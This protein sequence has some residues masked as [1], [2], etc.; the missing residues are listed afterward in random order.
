M[1]GTG[2]TQ[3]DF[4]GPFELSPVWRR[5]QQPNASTP[6]PSSTVS[7]SRSRPCQSGVRVAHM[8]G[9]YSSSRS[10][11]PSLAEPAARTVAWFYREPGGEVL[12]PSVI[13]TLCTLWRCGE[14]TD[15]SLVRP[16]GS[17][18]FVRVRDAPALLLMLQ[19]QDGPLQP[20]SPQ[21]GAGYGA[22]GL[23]RGR[24]PTSERCALS[25][26]ESCEEALTPGRRAGTSSKLSVPSWRAQERSLRPTWQ[27]LK[28]GEGTAWRSSPASGLCCRHSDKS[29]QCSDGLRSSVRPRGT[30]RRDWTRRRRDSLFWQNVRAPNSV[31]ASLACS[32]A[33]RRR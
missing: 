1:S 22:V 13:E 30:T 23:S 8:H 20:P 31:H 19:S 12:G 28:T 6:V 17:S 15:D 32:K 27:P 26:A 9:A 4:G 5:A 10:G 11:V 24:A 18:R 2:I 25:R 14:V 3:R 33:R 21:L 16:E 7:V 29:V